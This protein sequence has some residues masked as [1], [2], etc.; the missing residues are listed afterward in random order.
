MARPLVSYELWELSG[1]LSPMMR[2]R[3]VTARGKGGSN[4]YSEHAQNRENDIGDLAEHE[5]HAEC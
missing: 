4:L 5:R 3:R 2:S 1:P